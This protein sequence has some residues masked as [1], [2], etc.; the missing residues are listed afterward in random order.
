ML[1]LLNGCIVDNVNSSIYIII[2]FVEGLGNQ[3]QNFMSLDWI[4]YLTGSGLTILGFIISNRIKKKDDK[5]NIIVMLLQNNQKLI[6]LIYKGAYN[7]DKIDYLGLRRELEEYNITMIMPRNLRLEFNKLY[8]IYYMPAHEYDRHKDEIYEIL[9]NLKN[10][11]DR[12][13]EDVIGGNK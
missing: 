2:K 4:D 7:K 10:M 5:R 13:G 6:T 12:Y 11:L 1:N 9:C 8:K 3:N